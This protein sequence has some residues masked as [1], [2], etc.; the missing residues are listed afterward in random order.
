MP[1]SKSEHVVALAQEI[2]D[3]AELSR[4]SVSALVLKASRLAR[5]VGD[6]EAIS[7]LG[8]ERTGYADTPLADLYMCRTARWN[9]ASRSSAYWGTISEQEAIV[10]TDRREVEALHG[11]QAHGDY[12]TIQQDAHHKR[13]QA[14]S[15]STMRVTGIITR[16]RGLVQDFATRVYYEALF[17]GAAQ[18]MFDQYRSDVRGDGGEGG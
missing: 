9:D 5:L 1:E 10:E 2:I 12:P 3:D 7:W 6:E 8:W 15:V 4:G 11:F 16:V 14:L 13:L 17:G 18:S